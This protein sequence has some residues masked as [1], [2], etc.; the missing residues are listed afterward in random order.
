MALSEEARK[1]VQE[2]FAYAFVDASEQNQKFIDVITEHVKTN[3]N[4]LHAMEESNKQMAEIS[5]NVAL[6]VKTLNNGLSTKI[7]TIKDNVSVLKDDFHAENGAIP[8]MKEEVRSMKNHQKSLW[9]P[10]IGLLLTT[11]A[12]ASAAFDKQPTQQE[13]SPSAIEQVQDAYRHGLEDGLKLENVDD[14]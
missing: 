2:L 1:E 12:L 6:T 10:L 7:N 14:E 8:Q 13:V 11:L 9:I 3:Q 5:S 4:I